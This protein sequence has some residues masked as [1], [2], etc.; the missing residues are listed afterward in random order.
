MEV[1][2]VEI[3][4]QSRPGSHTLLAEPSPAQAASQQLEPD[5]LK[6]NT[7]QFVVPE[8]VTSPG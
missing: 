3:P 7:S 6:W 2:K 1:R 8:K 4:A 5:R